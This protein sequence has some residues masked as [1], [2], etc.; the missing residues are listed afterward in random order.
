[1]GLLV[2]TLELRAL[3]PEQTAPQ[4]G[5]EA[6]VVSPKEQQKSWVLLAPPPAPVS[7]TSRESACILKTLMTW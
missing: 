1:M 3:P 2:F 4:A 7:N 6:T 5:A